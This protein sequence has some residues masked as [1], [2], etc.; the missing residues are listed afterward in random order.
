MHVTDK[1]YVG[2]Q[3]ELRPGVEQGGLLVQTHD[4]VGCANPDLLIGTGFKIQLKSVAIK[5]FPLLL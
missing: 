2:R 5:L 3:G 4:R 1:Q